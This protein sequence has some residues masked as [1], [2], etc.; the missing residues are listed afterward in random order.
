MGLC[1]WES[2]GVLAHQRPKGPRGP[3]YNL[4]A[5]VFPL[6]RGHILGGAVVQGGADNL[7]FPPT[8]PGRVRCLHRSVFQSCA[9][10]QQCFQPFSEHRP[11]NRN[12]EVP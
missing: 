2:S 10:V 6:V 12:E 8:I 9:T 11:L 4:L 3:E 7:Q 1:S 5:L